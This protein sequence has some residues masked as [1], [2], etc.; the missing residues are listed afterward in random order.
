MINTSQIN[1]SQNIKLVDPNFNKPGDINML[2]SS[3]LFWSLC[4]ANILKQKCTP[5][6]KKNCKQLIK[7]SN[8][9]GNQ[10]INDFEK[11]W[12]VE[13][14]PEISPLT[15]EGRRCEEHFQS[16]TRKSVRMLPAHCSKTFLFTRTQVTAKLIPSRIIF[17]F[18]EGVCAVGSNG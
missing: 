2:I 17:Q 9:S 10:T 16:T 11:F 1:I 15:K 4:G 8:V 3:E 7:I 14:Q 18:Y 6:Y 5:H 13:E 12:D